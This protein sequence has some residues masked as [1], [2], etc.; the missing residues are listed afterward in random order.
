MKEQIR[1]ISDIL[2]KY[3]S[4]ND[5]VKETIFLHVKMAYAIGKKH[6][7]KES[8]ESLNGLKIFGG[9]L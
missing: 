5:I 4:I 6:G 1:E 7:A 3:P 9:K 8:L 2:N